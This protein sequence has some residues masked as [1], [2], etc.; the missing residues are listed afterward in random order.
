MLSQS[1]LSQCQPDNDRHG[2]THQQIQRIKGGLEENTSVRLQLEC[3][4]FPEVSRLG[5]R[6]SLW[7]SLS[8]FMRS[9][10][11]RMLYLMFSK[12]NSWYPSLSHIQPSPICLTPAGVWGVTGTDLILLCLM[13]LYFILQNFCYIYLVL[14][15]APYTFRVQWSRI[16]TIPF[17]NYNIEWWTYV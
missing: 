8:R 7:E 6:R 13:N 16:F 15:L 4:S 14:R 11:M 5:A 9:F 12:I 2:N 1:Q 17:F 3:K 10:C